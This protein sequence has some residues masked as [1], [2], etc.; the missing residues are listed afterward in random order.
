VAGRSA[1]AASVSS[2]TL[3]STSAVGLDL[4]PGCAHRSRRALSTANTTAPTSSPPAALM[5]PPCSYASSNNSNASAVISAPAAN[6]RSIASSRFGSL[7][8]TPISA[9]I[10]SALDATSP[11]HNAVITRSVWAGAMV[12]ERD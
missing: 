11:N 3:P 10:T 5:M 12:A 2:F 7:N 8:R 9:P 6:D 1:A 4:D